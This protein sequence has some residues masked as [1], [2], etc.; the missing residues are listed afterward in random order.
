MRISSG[1]SGQCVWI[2]SVLCSF[3]DWVRLMSLMETM[4]REEGSLRDS[5]RIESYANEE[6]NS[7]IAGHH[8]MRVPSFVRFHAFISVR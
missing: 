6:R 3:D 5:S 2:K 8:K 4:Q 7:E 1:L